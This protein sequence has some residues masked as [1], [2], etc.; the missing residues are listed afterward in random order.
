MVIYPFSPHEAEQVRQIAS[1]LSTSVFLY[2][3]PDQFLPLASAVGAALGFLLI[4]WHRLAALF[5][6]VWHFFRK[7]KTPSK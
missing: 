6:K 4:V 5:R 2:V 7:E 1:F 3:S